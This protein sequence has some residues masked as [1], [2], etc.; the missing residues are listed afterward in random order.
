MTPAELFGKRVRVAR[1]TAGLTLEKTAEKAQLNSNHLSQ[2]ERGT[3]RPSFEVIF[4]LARVLNVP[5][6]T[7]FV[8]EREENDEKTLRRK[9][10]RLLQDLP[11]EQLGQTFRFLKFVVGR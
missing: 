2:I 8:F 9:I 7:F 10:D 4:V 1:K 5:A 6:M 3:R 11:I